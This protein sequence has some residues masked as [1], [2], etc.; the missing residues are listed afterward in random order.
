MNEVEKSRDSRKITIA[1]VLILTLMVTTTGGTYA[2]FALTADNNSVVTGTVAQVGLQLTVT[3]AALGGTN[4]GATKTNVM[5]PQLETALGTA[6]GNNYKCVDGNGN[7]VC[8]VYTISLKNNSTSA[9]RVIG[10]VKF[11]GGIS[12]MPNLK[13]R[14]IA[15]V[16]S[17]GSYT[18]NTSSLG[19]T[20]AYDLLDGTTGT[21]SATAPTAC[22]YNTASAT[23]T[24]C[25]TE[26]IAAGATK[27][28]YIVIWI[29]ET[30][31]AQ[32]DGQT[33]T[34]ANRTFTATVSFVGENGTGVTSTIRG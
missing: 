17:L 19:G 34:T 13:W 5:V 15:G 6:I 9:V 14:R 32:T 12:I 2:Y 31:S 24:G 8:K 27:T 30:G 7:T 3:E 4:S 29:Q 33:A 18:A 10:T 22:T 23:Q 11:G 1:L 20:A 16:T 25:T 28:Y 21:S 26:F